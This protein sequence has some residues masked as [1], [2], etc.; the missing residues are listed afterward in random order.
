MNMGTFKKMLSVMCCWCLCLS[1]SSFSIAEESNKIKEKPNVKAQML[2]EQKIALEKERLS[3]TPSTFEKNENKARLTEK[4]AMTIDRIAN[5]KVSFEKNSTKE[6][7]RL[8]KELR[9]LNFEGPILHE[10]FTVAPSS[11]SR[12]DALFS[13]TICGDYWA[14][15]T[16]WILLDTSNW[17]AMGSDAWIAHSGLDYTCDEWSTSL[18]AGTYMFI[19]GDS[20]CDGGA[21]AELSLDGVSLGSVASGYSDPYSS[22]SGVCEAQFTFDVTDDASDD[23]G[24]DGG[25]DGAGDDGGEEPATYSASFSITGLDDCEFASITG[26]FDGWTGWGTALCDEGLGVSCDGVTTATIEGLADGSTHEYLIIC[27]SGD[28]WWNDIWANQLLQPELGS[29]CDFLA[30]DY[31]NYGFTVNGADVEVEYCAGTCDSACAGPPPTC[32]DQGLASCTEVD[33]GSECTYTFWVCDGYADCSTGLDEEGCAELTCEDQGLWDCGDGQC[34]PPSY[35]CD[36]VDYLCSAPWGPD[37][38]NGADEGLEACA[39]VSGYADQCNAVCNE[40]LTPCDAGYDLDCDNDY[41]LD[42][43]TAICVVN[44]AS[45]FTCEAIEYYGYDCS[46]LA[47]CG[48]CPV[49]EDPCDLAGGNSSYLADGWCDASNNNADC[50]YDAGDCC[51][52][53]C[54]DSVYSCDQYGG[55]CDTCIDPAAEDANY[56]G[57]CADAPVCGDGVCEEGE[58]GGDNGC[59]ADCGCLEGEFECVSGGSYGNC[60][61]A[62]WQCDGWDD[63][64]DAA[65]EAGCNDLT[66][67]DLGQWDCGDGQCIPLSYVCDGSIDTCNAGW[68]PDC[69]NGADESLETCGE[70]HDECVEVDCDL[71]W[72]TCLSSLADY[73]Y[74]NGTNWY[75]D[76]SAC[77]D[78][79]AQNPDVPQLTADCGAHAYNIGAGVCP[80]PCA[81]PVDPCVEAGGNPAWIGDGYC[82][83]DGTGIGNNQAACDFDGGDC[84]PGDCVDTPSYDCATYGG[85]CEDCLDPDSA[86]F[87]E[88]GA[89]SDIVLGCTSVYADNYNPDATADDGSCLYAG[90]EEAG[91]LPGCSEQDAEDGCFSD[92]WVGDGY[93]DG[94][95][96]AY[97]VNLCCYDLDGGDCTEAECEAPAV[98]DATITGLAAETTD[99]D[100]Y[101]DGTLYPAVNWT[102]DA[103]SDGTACEDNGEVTCPDGSC[104]ASEEDC[105][106]IPFADCLGTIS[107]IGDGYCDPTNNNAECGWDLGDCCPT[108]CEEAVA[109]GCPENPD[110]CYSTISCGDCSTCDDPDSADLAEGGACSDYEQAT[111]AEC[112][113][114]VTV[115]GSD[116]VTGDGYVDSCYS[117]G[118]GY[119]AFNWEGGCTA[120]QIYYVDSEGLDQI[121]DLTAYGFTSGFWFSGFG[122]SEEVPFVLTFNEDS[123]PTLVATTDCETPPVGCGDGYWDCGDGQCIPESYLCDG[124]SEFGN[125]GWGPDC[126]NGADEVLADCCA[127]GAGAYSG[128]CGDDSADDGG[129]PEGCDVDEYDCGANNGGCIPGYWVNDYYCDCIDCSDEYYYGRDN[130]V[131]LTSRNVIST[132][133]ALNEKIHAETIAKYKKSTISHEKVEKVAY[134]AI[135]DIRSGEITYTSNHDANRAVSYTVNVVCE[136]CVGGAPWAGTFTAQTSEFLIWGADSGSTLCASVIGISDVLGV[137]AESDI[138]CGDAGQGGGGPECGQYDCTG[139]A[140]ADDYLSWIGDGYCDD[141][142]WGIDF[143]SCGDF[144]CDNGDCGTELVNGECVEVAS[145]TAGDVNEDD[146]LNVQDIVVMVGYILDGSS[147]DVVE[148]CGDTNADGSVNV[149]DIVV[150]VNYILGGRTTSDATEARLNINDGIASL[151]ANGFVGAVQMTLS[152]EAGFSI[153][154]TNKA[155]V[156][157]YRTD[158]NS[159][160]LIIVAPDSDELFTASGSFNVEEVIVANENSQVTVMMPSELTLSKAYPNPFNPSTSMNIYVPADGIVSLSVYNVMGQEVATLHSGNMSAGNHT[161]TWNASNMTSGMYFVRAES[162]AGVAVQKVMLMK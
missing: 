55:T 93:C 111:D 84:C 1:L 98:W 34:I 6:E 23:G 96:E 14:Y 112:A 45:G 143:V 16:S 72:A 90:C 31:A 82:D 71:G 139:V 135:L 149:Q 120:T 43:D 73:D 110:G 76:C 92:S 119:F 157:D 87:D 20:A 99:F 141:G 127:A 121:L 53:T 114:S 125:A 161:V 126:A 80:D 57:S 24:D 102:W 4:E 103:L 21:T 27:A 19:L 9:R 17:F 59:Y 144:N 130:N 134:E 113:A 106:E 62:S 91:T 3:G 137:T 160:T 74:Y 159:T 131:T 32:A 154:L 147:A 47:A 129:E 158:G 89:C 148:S 66:C 70:A 101:G 18:P 25:D 124:S 65:D 52:S 50:G 105:P 10:R 26:T 38:V 142:T 8:K 145:C 156:A 132:N 79:C 108:S 123:S 150:L 48:G 81:G 118:S 69:A 13:A 15:E 133:K 104:A 39:E 153:E 78:T 116:D 7:I 97:G 107:W 95:D 140:C 42:D 85:T 155:M 128:L 109:A 67:E 22:Y 152:H 29:D 94:Y 138:V 122:F 33:D 40:G 75:A 100:P 162:Q 64:A 86:D 60:L 28:G 44:V 56:G 117:D 30:D 77:A 49:V 35:V 54:V 58:I 41:Y 36:G 83:G 5:T 46:A 68:G 136:A 61:P 88:G 51:P 37:C 63:C 11:E 12:D 115:S 146:D 2:L 151:D